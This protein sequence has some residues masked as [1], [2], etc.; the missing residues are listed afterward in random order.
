MLLHYLG[1]KENIPLVLMRLLG[2]VVRKCFV[3]LGIDFK[4]PNQGP[5]GLGMEVRIQPKGQIPPPSPGWPTHGPTSLPFFHPVQ[6]FLLPILPPVAHLESLCWHYLCASRRWRQSTEASTH[7]CTDLTHSGMA[8]M[9]FMACLQPDW[10]STRDLCRLRR[11]GWIA[12]PLV[13]S[14][15]LPSFCREI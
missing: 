15:N 14:C 10:V 7:L 5:P 13:L 11:G 4:Q 6:P 2:V 3:V 1:K 9:C 8:Q 12:L